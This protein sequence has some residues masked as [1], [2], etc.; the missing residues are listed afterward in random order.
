MARVGACR[1][2]CR[3]DSNVSQSI[4]AVWRT[5]KVHQHEAY[6]WLRATGPHAFTRLDTCVFWTVRP[7]HITHARP[8]SLTRTVHIRERRCLFISLQQAVSGASVPQYRAMDESDL[9]KS[10]TIQMHQA[11]HVDLELIP[12]FHLNFKQDSTTIANV[13]CGCYQLSAF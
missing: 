13:S 2:R 12:T 6:V 3:L 11:W 10:V 4:L 9:Y 1:D 7:A 5:F 8:R